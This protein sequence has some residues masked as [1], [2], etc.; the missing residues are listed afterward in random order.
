MNLLNP[1]PPNLFLTLIRSLTRAAIEIIEN[2]PLDHFIS[3]VIDV[4]LRF[5]ASRLCRLIT[6]T[7]L[8]EVIM[9]LKHSLIE[10]GHCVNALCSIVK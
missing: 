10:N 9:K 5:C 6:D 2:Q 1:S 7:A 3:V 4:C 8:N